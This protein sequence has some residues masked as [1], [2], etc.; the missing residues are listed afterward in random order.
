M[1]KKILF[2]LLISVFFTACTN[3]KEHIVSTHPN[4]KTAFA[5]YFSDKDTI[6]PI[7]S[8]RY[9]FNGEKQEEISYRDGI[10]NGPYIFWFPNGEKMFE[11]TYKNGLLDG[12]FTQW[13]D[14]GEI[15]YI[16]HYENGR[17]SGTWEYY[18]KEGKLLSKQKMK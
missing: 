18:S 1:R 13:Y 7:R 9:Y 4:G 8:L 11:G 2:C 14:N 5:E 10:K 3:E 17:P 16:A 12:T 6:N 15:D